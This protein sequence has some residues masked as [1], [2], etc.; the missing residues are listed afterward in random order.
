MTRIRVLV[1]REA[2]ASDLPLPQLMTPGSSGMDLCSAEPGEVVVPAG[3]LR[4]VRTGLRIAIPAGYEAQI[5]PRSGLALK[6]GV[7][8]ANSP[9]TIDSDYRGPISLIVINHG[10]D[11]F[12]V[13]RGMRVAQMVFQEVVTP[14]LELVESLDLTERAEGGFGHTGH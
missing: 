13:S 4:L 9:G 3:E 2:H 8:L 12:R 11:V 7:T 10:Q 1:Q 6:H 14:E 5:R